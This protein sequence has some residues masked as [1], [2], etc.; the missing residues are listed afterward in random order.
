[1]TKSESMARC[2]HTPDF[3][4]GISGLGFLSVPLRGIIHHLSLPLLLSSLAMSGWGEEVLGEA[5]ERA[6]HYEATEG[7]DDP[8]AL[9]QKRLAEGAA[10]LKFDPRRGYLDSL[11]KELRVPVSSQVLVF[12]KTSSQHEQ[13]SPKTPRAVYF[14]DEISVA[15]VPGGPVIDVAS[16]DPNRGPIFYTLAQRPDAVPKFTRGV[17]CLQCHLGNKTLQV[18]GLLV[19]SVYTSV[20]GTP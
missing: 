18:P 12:S 20:D 17:D 2:P 7:L 11:L 10:T 19:R 6:I 13:T 14:A 3:G 8:V 16:V 5:Q 15:W 4:F 9:L 1:M